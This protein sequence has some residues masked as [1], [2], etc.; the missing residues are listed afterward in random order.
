MGLALDGSSCRSPSCFLFSQLLSLSRSPWDDGND[1]SLSH[2]QSYLNMIISPLHQI[3]LAAGSFRRQLL[4]TCS[5][6]SSLTSPSVHLTFHNNSSVAIMQLCNPRR[7]NALTYSMM[8]QLDNH[9][10]TLNEWCKCDDVGNDARVLIL[11]GSE[12]NFCSGLDLLD[13]EQTDDN[14]KPHPLKEGSNMNSHMTR[15]TNHLHSLPILSISAIDGFAIG[16]GAELTTSTDMVAL[17]RSSK[18]QFVHAQR[19]ASMGW[20]GGRRLVKKVGRS[21]ALR[22]LLLGECVLGEEEAKSATYADAVASEGETALDAA[23]RLI[24]NPILDLPCAKSIRAIKSAVSSA[25]GDRDVLDYIDGTLQSNNLA[26]RGERESFLSVWGGDTNV[27]QIRKAK[28]R[29]KG[30]TKTT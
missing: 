17:S 18:I 25:D 12:G 22:M 15:L 14:D 29:L 26:L 19:G 8:Q 27:E 11:T 6:A 5:S 7:R 2:Q 16:G 9:I 24:V 10:H 21:R 20:G 30:K 23:M 28:E 3:Q 13:H 4:S 1:L